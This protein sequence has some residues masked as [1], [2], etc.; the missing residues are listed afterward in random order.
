MNY[1]KI[2]LSQ[3]PSLNALVQTKNE[4]ILSTVTVYFNATIAPT[5]WC[6]YHLH[7]KS[8]GAVEGR[9]QVLKEGAGQAQ[10]QY[11]IFYAYG[12]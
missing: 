6:I 7:D 2:F 10:G 3:G 1:H 9:I 12:E 11:F 5:H 8:M 4:Y